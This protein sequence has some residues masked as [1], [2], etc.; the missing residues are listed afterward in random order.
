[1]SDQ[2]N[3]S[4]SHAISRRT[5]TLGAAWAVPSIALAAS[6]PAQA[7]STAPDCV[8]SRTSLSWS[9][10]LGTF[11]GTPVPANSLYG[12]TPITGY[13]GWTFRP[14]ALQAWNESI[15]TSST[16][17]NS[18]PTTANL[19]MRSMAGGYS[20][21][22]NLGWYAG[23]DF[24]SPHASPSGTNVKGCWTFEFSPA[25]CNLTFAI[26][27]IDWGVRESVYFTTPGTIPIGTIVDTTAVSGVGTSASPWT[28]KLSGIDLDNSISNRGNV[29]VSFTGSVAKFT[30]CADSR[31]ATANSFQENVAISDFSFGCHVTSSCA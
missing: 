4:L 21:G 18:V 19:A 24:T 28:S 20:S 22:V 16:Y 25:L 6:A 2:T 26:T 3:A 12:S 15:T 1:M 10:G 5:L 31:G 14:Y 9:Y 8:A 30:I 23:T 13:T 29:N 7:S 11:S 17:T 27:D